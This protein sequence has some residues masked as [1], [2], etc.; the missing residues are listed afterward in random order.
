MPRCGQGRHSLELSR[1][2]VQI[3]L[4]DL[5]ND[6]SIPYV[7]GF[8]GEDFGFDSE[9]GDFLLRETLARSIPV[10]RSSGLRSR[11]HQIFL[12]TNLFRL[13]VG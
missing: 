2:G 12:R 4:D 5:L 7:V 8:L 3:G 11:D 13:R 1:F 9:F 6:A 10:N